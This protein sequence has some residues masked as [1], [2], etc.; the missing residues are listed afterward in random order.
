MCAAWLLEWGVPFALLHCVSAYPTPPDKANLCWIGELAARFGVPVGY[1]D[2]T[3]DTLAGALASAAGA[4]II[5][6]HLTYDRSARGPDHATSADAAQFE[7]Y[8]KHVRD[9]DRMRGIPGKHVLEIE[10]DVRKVSRQSLVVRRSLKPGDVLREEDLTV[11]RPG[12]GL[13]AAMIDKA[14]GR[15]VARPVA[16]GTLLHPDMLADAA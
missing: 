14:I 8:V 12:T 10:Q 15:T 1:S 11:Q 4:A 7:R 3:T 13:P 16:A 5:E 2:H 9:A 6:K